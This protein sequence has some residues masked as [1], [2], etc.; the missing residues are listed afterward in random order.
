[1]IIIKAAETIIVSVMYYG[2]LFP[3]ELIVSVSG[4]PEE[5]ILV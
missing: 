3:N 1:M 4:M 2:T 5:V